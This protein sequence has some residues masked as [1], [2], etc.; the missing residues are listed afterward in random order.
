MSHTSGTQGDTLLRQAAL[1]A[2]LE[3]GQR[4]LDRYEIRRVLGRG[5]FGQVLEVRDSHS[6]VDYALKRLPPELAGTQDKTALQKVYD[7]WA[8]LIGLSKPDPVK[9]AN[10]TPG[11]SRRNRE[12]NKFTWWRD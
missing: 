9:V 12:R 7:Q 11:L 1:D 10:Y 3:L 2:G 5:A 6:G 8:K 4:L